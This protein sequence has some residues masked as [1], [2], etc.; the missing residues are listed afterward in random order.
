MRRYIYLYPPAIACS[1]S[2]VLTDAEA[3]VTIKEG[4]SQILSILAPARIVIIISQ[5][6]IPTKTIWWATRDSNP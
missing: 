2:V 6:S 4:K 1:I 5:L 3:P